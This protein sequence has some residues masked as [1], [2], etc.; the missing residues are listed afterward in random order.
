[1]N[2]G[3]V[4]LCPLAISVRYSNCLFSFLSISI[5]SQAKFNYYFACHTFRSSRSQLFSSLISVSRGQTA[6]ELNARCSHDMDCS[7]SIKGSLCSMA[8]LCECKPYYARYNDTTCVQGELNGFDERRSV[9]N[10]KVNSSDGMRRHRIEEIKRWRT[11][12]R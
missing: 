9:W 8:G 11:Q 10:D 6:L 5:S 7:D 12:T 3:A 1:M 2:D 4:K